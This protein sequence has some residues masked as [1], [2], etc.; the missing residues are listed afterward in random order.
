MFGLWRVA[1][2]VREVADER[3]NWRRTPTSRGELRRAASSQMKPRQV[4]TWTTLAVRTSISFDLAPRL[5]CVKFV[6]SARV[7]HG[8]RIQLRNRA[9]RTDNK[10]PKCLFSA[11]LCT[12]AARSRLVIR[13]VGD[14][15][16]GR[17]ERPIRVDVLIA[18]RR[19]IVDIVGLRLGRRRV[20]LEGAH[21]G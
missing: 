21:F 6:R 19:L 17:G 3:I 20:D 15:A 4:D 5:N 10:H 11:N 8:D 16:A 2:G 7:I 9:K 1:L 12:Q 18:E 14:I 13:T